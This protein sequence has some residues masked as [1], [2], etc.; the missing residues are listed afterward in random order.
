MCSLARLKGQIMQGQRPTR[1]QNPAAFRTTRARRDAARSRPWRGAPDY[2][3]DGREAEA[4]DIQLETLAG[5]SKGNSA[6]IALNRGVRP[7]MVYS[8]NRGMAGWGMPPRGTCE[9]AFP[10]KADILRES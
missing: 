10:L 1:H 8:E 7:D 5:S 2:L 6:K 4:I 3:S 9:S